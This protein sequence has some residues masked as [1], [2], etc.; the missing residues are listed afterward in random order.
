[1]VA[2]A[3]REEEAE[4]EVLNANLTKL[5]LLTKKIQGSIVRLD[6]SGQIV[7]EAI[8][9]I[10]SNTQ[11]LQITNQNIDRI[12]DAIERLRQPLDAKGREEGV[13][14]AGPEN[15]G[16]QQ[17]LGALKRVDNALKDLTSSN[18][19]SNQQTIADFNKLLAFGSNQLQDLLRRTLENV[20]PVEPLHYITK[21]LEFPTFSDQQASHIRQIAEAITS[22]SAQFSG[23]GKRQENPEV[24]IYEEIRG[25]YLSNSLQNLATASINTSTKRGPDA[26]I[27]R[28]GTSGIGAYASGLQGMI[29]AEADNITKVF[30]TNEAAQAIEATCQNALAEFTKTLRDLNVFIKSRIL[31]DCFLAFEI[32]DLVTPVSYNLEPRTGTIL[33]S[34]FSDALRPIRE[35]ARSSLSDLLEQ[36]R[37]RS[38][39][40]AVLPNDG[41]TIPIVSDT[42]QRLS[43][44][45]IYSQPLKTILSSIG[46]G[47]WRA[48]SPT[49]PPSNLDPNTTPDSN[50]LLS[51]YLF[52]TLDTLFTS[53]EARAKS[54]HRS[55]SLQGCFLSNTFALI[56]RSI[57]SSPDLSRALTTSA[58]HTTRLDSWR[59][60]AS[61]LYLDAWK[62]PSSHL[63][64]VQ[65]TSRSSG[66][67]SN[68]SSSTNKD[69]TR[70]LSGTAL[71]SAT[72][73]KGLSSKDRDKIKEKFKAFNSSFDEM[74]ARHK[75]LYMEREVR[76]ALSREVQAMIEPLYARFWDRYHELDKGK[77][78]IVKY[79]KADLATLL[80]GLA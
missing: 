26:G 23:P 40:V 8:G 32:I 19:R 60:K 53:L 12:S 30:L 39:T 59:K 13:I 68:T 1:M 44:L 42:M 3:H 16:L 33:K 17:Y 61:S 46:D 38:S 71:D 6:T 37:Q 63:L 28:E 22:A 18:L 21:G 57:R 76:S 64:D 10:Y 51:N 24:R 7:K 66:T 4:V 27:Y 62:D 14:R 5:K 31:T 70:P 9:P 29:S 47:N 54:F 2:Q 35:T 72:I 52:D 34:Q 20:R 77:G 79:S 69:G 11:Q 67:T 15:A 56:D 45:S 55:K 73:V 80:V 36:T 78:K 41:N 75:S 50:I 49:N 58:I 74:V 43:T 25:P 48:S 65:Y